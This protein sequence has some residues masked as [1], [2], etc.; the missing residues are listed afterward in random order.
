[1]M[2]EEEEA[3][4]MDQKQERRQEQGE[5]QGKEGRREACAQRHCR[6]LCRLWTSRCRE[7]AVLRLARAWSK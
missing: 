5:K 1:M 4:E 7:R 2:K 3:E 6:G